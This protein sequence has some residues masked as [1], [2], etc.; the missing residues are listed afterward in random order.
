MPIAAIELFM[1]VIFRNS[2]RHTTRLYL[3][4]MLD[5]KLFGGG[6][7]TAITM[8]KKLLPQ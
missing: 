1:A 3:I 7:H 5:K 6:Y 4:C 2:K 8:H